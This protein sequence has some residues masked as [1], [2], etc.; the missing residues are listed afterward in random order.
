V[1]DD[2]VAAFGHRTE[3]GRRSRSWCTP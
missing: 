2:H 1:Q 3:E